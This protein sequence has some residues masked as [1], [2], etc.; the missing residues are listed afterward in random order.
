MDMFG[1]E[2]QLPPTKAKKLENSKEKLFY[3][4]VFCNINEH[5]FIPLYSKNGSRPNAPVNTLVSSIVLQYHNGWSTNELLSNI[6][7]N[8]LTRKALGLHN[9]EV[10]PF[11]EATYY[12]F[13]HKLLTHWIQTGENLIENVF[14]NLTKEQLKKL[15][16]K[17]SIQRMDS[18]Q[19]LSNIRDYS[20]VQLLIECM[21]RLDRILKEA[22]KETFNEI[23]NKYCK[24]TSAKY[25][26]D[27]K[28]NDIPHELEKLGNAYYEIHSALK[29]TYSE[30]KAFQIFQRAYTENFIEEQG[31]VT[32][33]E[34]SKLSGKILQSPDD[35][36][37]TYRKKNKKKNKGQ[38]VNVSETAH[39]DNELNLIIDIAVAQNITDDSKILNSRIDNIKEKT[40]DLNELHTDGA[41][42]S[43]EN[44]IK[45]EEY[46]I[47]HVQTDGRGKDSVI[48]IDIEE[49]DD[50]ELV[51][52]CPI[53]EAKVTNTKSR[54]KACFDKK[55]CNNC[56]YNE[57]CNTK[58]QKNCRVYYF[59]KKNIAQQ[60]RKKNLHNLPEDR[61]T[62]RPNVEATMKEF[63]KAFNHK[64]KLKTRGKFKA[65]IFAFAMGVGINFGRIFRHFNYNPET[66]T[67]VLQFLLWLLVI[68]IL[69]LLPK[70]FDGKLYGEY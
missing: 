2:Y 44:D 1:V 58:E 60:K 38:V 28:K 40:S 9:L 39:P 10:T 22:D 23:L 63:T 61:Q 35:L 43:F 37:A 20:R 36:D 57:T 7:F 52:K 47:N 66:Y 54:F 31:I 26:Y 64:G 56:S 11:C 69:F 29:E 50:N 15:N 42:G 68:Y 27:L 45:M 53:Q 70:T 32:V 34:S 59:D 41:Y 33:I 4:L 13:Q 12:N 51:V 3:E 25:V 49:T 19:A 30:E 46:E 21:I 67:F 17:T 14:N 55:I 18:F 65:M 16:I 8:I 5:D 62:I 24:R 48:P 6:D